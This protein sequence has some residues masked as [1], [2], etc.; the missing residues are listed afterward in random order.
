MISRRSLLASLG[1]ALL[2]ATVAAGAQ[3]ATVQRL[4]HHAKRHMHAASTHTLHHR[5]VHRTASVQHSRPQA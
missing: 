3:A 4:P 1:L 5:K 2:A